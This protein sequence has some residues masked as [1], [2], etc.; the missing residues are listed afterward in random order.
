MPELAPSSARSP[1]DDA[2]GAAAR[3]RAHDRGAAAD[4]GAVADDDALRDAALDHRRAERAR[5]EVHEA[6]VH[7]GGA[8]GEVGAEAHARGVG[9][10]HPVGHDVVEQPRELVDARHA[11]CRARC[12]AGPESRRSRPDAP[13]RRSSRRR[14]AGAPKRPS[15]LIVFGLHEQVAEQV[16]AQVRVRGGG[17]RGI[18]VDLDRH[19]LDG[20]SR[21]ASRSGERLEL[22]RRECGSTPSGA[23]SAGRGTRCR[24]PCRRRRSWRDRS[25]R[26]TVHGPRRQRIGGSP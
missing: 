8:G 22:G 25:P 6:L 14:S 23:P 2:L 9:D 18:E 20:T 5:V 15:R 21:R 4:V 26:R 17:G 7:D 12:S 11:R 16:Q 13:V 10:P 1:I 19:E 3:Q 24:A